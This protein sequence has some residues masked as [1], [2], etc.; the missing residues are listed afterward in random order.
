MAASADDDPATRSGT[1]QP[2]TVAYTE[3]AAVRWT[4][5]ASGMLRD[6]RLSAR[7]FAA[8]GVLS[9]RVWGPCP[10]CGHL[11]DDR[12]VHT[13]I[14]TGPRGWPL[15][16]RRRAVAPPPVLEVDVG[17]GCR[18]THPGAPEDVSGCGVGFRVELTVPDGR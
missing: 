8:D 10:R 18:H 9:S 4:D 15:R 17:C 3:S 2:E 11:L 1:T 7:A 6:G 14:V 12:Q 5:E 16:R 13:A